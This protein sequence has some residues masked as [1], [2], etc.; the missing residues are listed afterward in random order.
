M[1]IWNKVLIGLI[2]V[3]ALAFFYMAGRTLHTHKKWHES[4]Q[5][6]QKRIEETQQQNRRLEEGEG[7]GEDYRPGI[8]RLRLELQKMV[9]DRGRV[10]TQ[11]KPVAGQQT[12]QTGQVGVTVGQH[13]I[14]E[15]TLLFVFLEADADREGSYLGQFKV[16]MFNALDKNGDG[17]LEQAELPQP[18]QPHF[19]AA[20]INQNGALDADEFDDAKHNYAGPEILV[21]SMAMTGP[22]LKR[23]ASSAAG[24][25]TWTMY[26]IMP[27]D[28]HEAF[29]H[30]EEQKLKDLL[31]AGRVEEYLEDG[32]LLTTE[33]VEKTG[34][35][36]KVVAVDENRRVMYED[37]D[38]RLLYA[39]EVNADGRLV[40]VDEK[41]KFVCATAVDKKVDPDDGKIVYDVQYFD[42]GGQPLG[43]VSV[44][45][46]EVEDGEGKYLRWLRDY[47]VLLKS[48]HLQCSILIDLKEDAERDLKYVRDALAEAEEDYQ[49]FERE[50]T[51]LTTEKEKVEYQ[52]SVVNKLLRK[53]RGEVRAY[54]DA[55]DRLIAENRSVA[56]RIDAAQQ[57]AKRRID[58]RT[59]RMARTGTGEGT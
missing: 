48:Y 17:R 41:G 7:K 56:G 51:R 2:I 27:A 35:K 16:A 59:G 40:Y 39:S 45:E 4:A 34:L 13:G 19:A 37:Q 33:E 30:L 15:K 42:D 50:K 25:R 26:E 43:E 5:R 14:P 1:S 22:E 49:S 9:A 44:I 31:P 29:A 53:L 8:D 12:Q 54:H 28:S 23:L 6:H 21:P 18:L 36:G 47:E 11:C 3:A 46:K 52:L 24:N 20:D 58:A 55:V 38:G 32:E 57:E 10:W